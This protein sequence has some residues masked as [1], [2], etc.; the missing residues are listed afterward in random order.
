MRRLI[1][2][3]GIIMA[4]TA[5]AELD[6]ALED[7]STEKLNPG[8]IFTSAHVNL[9]QSDAAGNS[10]P[11]VASMVG[12]EVGFA[13]AG[14][15]WK[16]MEIGLSLSTGSLAYKPKSDSNSANV[17]LNVPLATMVRFGLGSVM[18]KG[19]VLLW[20]VAV[21]SFTSDYE[22]E[23]G[24]KKYTSSAAV[25]SVAWR[26]S[27]NYLLPFSETLQFE[28]GVQH[29]QITVNIDELKSGS[30]RMEADISDIIN[31]PAVTMGVRLSFGG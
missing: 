11:G 6:P 10:S 18:G 27:A 8:G 29:T 16:R 17:A 22:R 1:F 4:S 21:G 12:G 3:V 28:G 19:G 2:F 30:E 31:I 14:G 5:V 15:Y 26:L 25:P 24:G 13:F 7:V 20:N 9:G 23:F